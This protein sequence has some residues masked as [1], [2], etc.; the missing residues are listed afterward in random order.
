MS[1]FNKIVIERQKKE[2]ELEDKLVDLSSHKS[3]RIFTMTIIE[4]AVIIISGV[5]QIF[6][7]RKILI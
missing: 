7:L 2:R 5:Y 4:C 6:A 3:K 1:E